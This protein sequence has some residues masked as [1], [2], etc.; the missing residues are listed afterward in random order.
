LPRFFFNNLSRQRE[1]ASNRFLAQKDAFNYASPMIFQSV[2][3][4]LLI[5]L[6]GFS[7]CDPG[8]ES[9][10]DEQRDPHYL[11]GRNRVSSQDYKGAVEEFEKALEANPRSASAHFELGWLND[12]QIK[13]YAAAIYHYEQHLRLR[14]NSDYAERAKERIRSC[15]MD[16][17]KSEYLAPVSQGIQRD[18]ERLSAENIL[19]KRQ[20]EALQTQIAE[21]SLAQTVNPGTISHPTEQTP[22]AQPRSTQAETRVTP[23]PTVSQRP[24]THVVK[25]GET[26]TSIAAKYGVK[27]NVFLAANSRVNLDR[28]KIGQTV[29]IPSSSQ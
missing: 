21:R 11:N 5:L 9:S 8:S 12:E 1:P 6:L 22:I 10:L 14:P 17:V 29:N 20:L 15:K 28:L 3:C 19:L 27:W 13:N 25:A 16:L 24:K 26:A 2:R 18:L 23:P 4:M 7:G